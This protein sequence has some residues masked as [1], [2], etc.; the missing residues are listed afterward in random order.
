MVLHVTVSAPARGAAVA[1]PRAGRSGSPWPGWAQ[2]L[3]EVPLFQSLS[4]RHLRKV[5][6]LTHLRW[7]ANGMTV[8][9]AGRPGDAFY[10]ILNGHAELQLPDG[11]TKTLGADAFFGELALLDTAPRAA[12]VTS[13]GGLTT[14]R[15]ARPDFAQ[16]LREEPSIGLGLARGLVG[17]IRDVQG[18]GVVE[19]GGRP[20][21]ALVTHDA[22]AA[23]AGT[24][25]PETLSLVAEVP[26]FGSLNKRHLRRVVRL[27]ELK[28]YKGGKTVVREGARGDAFFI[29]L[30]GQARVETP[31][32]RGHG[33]G[34]GD[35]F[36]ELALLDGAPRAATVTAS[37]DLTTLR[38]GQAAFGKLLRDEPTIGVGLARGLAAIVRDLA[39]APG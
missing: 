31:D 2:L 19:Q 37:D 23:A 5:A 25:T 29:V 21:A 3:S 14:A 30:A 13:A 15:I 24:S 26:L 12:T 32:G 20:D 16:L 17:V 36:G 39:T 28:R 11:R 18:T 22:D 38:I 7:Y 35:Y 34:P 33:L 27:G 10:A 1:A 6:R 8:I 9:R 4:K